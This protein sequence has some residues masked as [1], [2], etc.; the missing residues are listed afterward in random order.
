M[1][2]RILERVVRLRDLR[3]RW[4]LVATANTPQTAS[5]LANAWAA[6]TIKNAQISL[7]HAWRA[8]ELQN[9]VFG[10]GCKLT[11]S[12]DEQAGTLWVCMRGSDEEQRGEFAASLLREAE[13]SHGLIPALSVAH[14][15]SAIPPS[16]PVFP[17]RRSLR[18]R[19]NI[20]RISS[21][22]AHCHASRL[23]G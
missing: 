3:G 17:D 12:T 15:E 7:D 11:E 20:C 16:R 1:Q 10:L 2:L 19:R 4:E 18:A 6:S 9:Q 23:F 14:L 5:D 22:N 8:S 21:G 13:L